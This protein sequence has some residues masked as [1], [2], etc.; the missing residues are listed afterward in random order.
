[1]H[2]NVL[3]SFGLPDPFP[4]RTVVNHTYAENTILTTGASGS[5]CG[6]HALFHIND[7]YAPGGQQAH[8]PYGFDQMTPLY[9]RFKV[10]R[11][12]ID[13]QAVNNQPVTTTSQPAQCLVG[14]AGGDSNTVLD[15]TGLSD[16]SVMEQTNCIYALQLGNYGSVERATRQIEIHRLFGITKAE[17]DADVSIFTGTGSSSPSRLCYFALAA[18]ALVGASTT[19]HYTI[20]FTFEV[21]WFERI[22]VAAS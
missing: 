5:I 15:P 3:G 13:L 18:S 14:V 16:I 12:V 6:A 2:S 10:R 19:V 11:V 20:R 1:V 8:Q 4:P 22:T 17:Y 21:E 7:M 9:K